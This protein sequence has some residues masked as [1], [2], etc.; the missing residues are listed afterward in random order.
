MTGTTRFG[1]TNPRFPLDF[2]ATFHP[3][4]ASVTL[5]LSLVYCREKEVSVCLIKQVRLVVP[6][7]V[8]PGGA[9]RLTIRY[10]LPA[11]RQKGGA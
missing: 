10:R 7:T 9:P 2:P 4:A 11:G 3:G 8:A 6:V 5:D 1:G